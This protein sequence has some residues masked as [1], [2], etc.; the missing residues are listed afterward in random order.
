MGRS[1]EAERVVVNVS[2]MLAVLI[3]D[4]PWIDREG[5]MRLLQE[6]ED[7]RLTAFV[8]DRF[9]DE[10]LGGVLKALAVQRPLLITADEIFHFLSRIP[11]IWCEKAKSGDLKMFGQRL[12]SLIAHM[13]T[14]FTFSWLVNTKRLCGLLIC[15]WFGI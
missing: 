14:Q 11:F 10:V 4:E 9:L 7:E 8:P 15:D 2:V 1:Q 13:P 5:S 6:M 12:K 3:L